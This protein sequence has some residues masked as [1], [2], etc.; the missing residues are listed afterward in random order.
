MKRRFTKDGVYM[1]ASSSGKDG[2]ARRGMHRRHPRAHLLQ[3]PAAHSRILSTAYKPRKKRPQPQSQR[4]AITVAAAKSR[5]SSSSR[6]TSSMASSGPRS[7]SSASSGSRSSS[8]SSAPSS[9]T[10]L[11]G[12]SSGSRPRSS[13]ATPTRGLSAAGGRTKQQQDASETEILRAVLRTPGRGRARSIHDVAT[14]EAAPGLAAL[15]YATWRDATGQPVNLTSTTLAMGKLVRL[16]QS[17]SVT[18]PLTHNLFLF[19][20]RCCLSPP[21][22]HTHRARTTCLQGG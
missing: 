9:P 3:P 15:S 5:Q 10:H 6:Y 16:Q 4:Q 12:S 13:P 11:R 20:P 1:G 17:P 14:P 2:R 18:L 8:S 22:T 7:T 19:C 21:H